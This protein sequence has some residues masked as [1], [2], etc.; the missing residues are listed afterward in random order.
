MANHVTAV[1]LTRNESPNIE[2]CLATLAWADDVMVLDS[3][4][5]DDT[6]ALAHGAGARV[7]QRRFRDWADQRNAALDLVAT[8][9]VLF[10]DADERVTPELASEAQDVVV[11][12]PEVGWWVPRHNYIVGHRMRAT[13]WFPDY[14]LRLF[15]RDRGWYN[16]QRRVHELVI[17]DGPAG[18]LDSPLIH[19]NYATWREFRERQA[20]YADHD[21]QML[22]AAGQ[23][24]RP[25]NLLLQPL[26]EFKRRF[27]TESGYRDGRHGLV[28]SLLMGYYEFVKYR[29]L[30]HLLRS[31]GG[32][33]GG[34]IAVD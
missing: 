32:A 11:R 15:R 7:Y 22:Y 30:W 13:G 16:P 23:Q 34:G 25:H 29:E 3:Y 24:A 28:L 8:E 18:Y 10:I 9:W 27:W 17:L 5:D 2:G 4:S 1:V 33:R 21:A 14:Q 26:R 6:V 31:E 19:Y 12:R 20:R